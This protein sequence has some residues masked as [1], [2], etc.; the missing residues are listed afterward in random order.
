MII[1]CSAIT[2]LCFHRNDTLISPSTISQEPPESFLCAAE[3]RHTIYKQ[4][5]PEFRVTSTSFKMKKPVKST[6]SAENPNEKPGLPP[7]QIFEKCPKTVQNKQATIRVH[8]W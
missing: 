4:P 6:A 1:D 8:G 2:T 7:A 5:Q 3:P